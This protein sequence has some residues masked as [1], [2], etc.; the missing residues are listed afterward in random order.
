MSKKEDIYRLGWDEYLEKELDVLLDKVQ[1]YVKENNIKID[2]VVPLLRGGNIPGTYLAYKLNI[3][4]IAPVQYKYFFKGDVANLVQMQKVN[5]DIFNK[6][7]ELT[8]LLVEGNHCYGTSAKY[9]AKGLKEQFPS[10]KIIYAASN[11]DY[12]YKDVV[13]EFAEVSLFGRYNNDCEEMGEEECLK[14]GIDFE[15]V[16]IFPWEDADEEWITFGEFKQ[17]PFKDVKEAEANSKLCEAIDLSEF[18]N[19]ESKEKNA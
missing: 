7:E 3:L 12:K 1:N 19:S 6:D 8:F 16:N 17:F 11:M 5:K 9:A 14:L 18:T 10:C 2:A 4:R 13:D 15:K